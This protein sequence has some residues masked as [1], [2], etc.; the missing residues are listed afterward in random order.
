MNGAAWRNRWV[1]VLT[2]ALAMFLT[3]LPMPVGAESLRPQWVAL[4]IIFWCLTRPG[5]VGVFWAFGV[6]LALDVLVGSLLGQQALGLSVVAYVTVILHTRIRLFPLW[7][8]SLFVWVLLLVERLLT[9]WVLGATG[10]PLPTLTYWLPTFVGL[11]LWPWLFAVLSAIEHR[12][13]AR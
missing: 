9:L 2:L 8:Q 5:R 7:Q 10:Q 6:G 13:G 4:T 1:V 11:L 12:F 3:I